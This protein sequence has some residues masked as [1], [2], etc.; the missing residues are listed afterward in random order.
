MAN[1]N[2]PF[3]NP[4]YRIVPEK[5]KV[6]ESVSISKGAGRMSSPDVNARRE[7]IGKERELLRSESARAF[8]RIPSSPSLILEGHEKRVDCIGKKPLV[9]D[10]NDGDDSHASRNS[11]IKSSIKTIREQ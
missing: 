3:K 10:D 9:L 4:P 5:I 6:K 2:T 1:S 7:K 11:F 8:R